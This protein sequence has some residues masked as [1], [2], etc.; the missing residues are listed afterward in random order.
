[1]DGHVTSYFEWLGAGIYSLDSRDGAMHGRAVLVKELHYGSDGGTLYLRLDFRT[2]EPA[3]LED[4]E[5]HI[6]AQQKTA[7]VRLLPDGVEVLETTLA[8]GAFECAF[9]AVLRR[10]C[11]S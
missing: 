9:R 5:I 8:Q 10:G 1:M 2:T 11:H 3:K 7:R 6:T 4:L